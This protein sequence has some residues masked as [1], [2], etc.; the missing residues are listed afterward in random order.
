MRTRSRLR[1]YPSGGCRAVT[2]TPRPAKGEVRARWP[3]AEFAR[4]PGGFTVPPRASGIE[5]EGPASDDQPTPSP[6]PSSPHSPRSSSVAAL[7]DPRAGPAPDLLVPERRLG[8]AALQIQSHTFICD[9]VTIGDGVFVGHGVIFINDKLPRA[10]TLEGELQRDK[11]WTLLCTT[12]DSG[13]SI[14]SGAV[15]LGG[16]RI[17]ENAVVGAGAVVTKHVA[18][19]EV[20]AGSPA[21]VLAAKVGPGTA[22]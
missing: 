20:V 11:D 17:G 4:L 2:V 9:G 6:R 5:G 16:V 21:R 19:G 22:V 8:R 10:T 12:V 15:I 13:A 1:V 3:A 7:H 18:P 14:G